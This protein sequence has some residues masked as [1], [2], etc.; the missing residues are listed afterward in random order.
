MI[1]SSKF[2]R[3]Y[4]QYYS[5]G[6]LKFLK[7]I[8][9]TLKLTFLK[10]LGLSRGNLNCKSLGHHFGGTFSGSA[11]ATHSTR[12]GKNSSKLS[13]FML[14]NEVGYPFAKR[15]GKLL[16]DRGGW[17][18]LLLLESAISNNT[19]SCKDEIKVKKIIILWLSQYKI[20]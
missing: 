10:R 1:P 2:H 18:P 6:F 19:I 20:E 8:E 5:I 11:S 16:S 12:N 15:I 9:E 3:V 7:I 13:I 14:F 4:S 17:S